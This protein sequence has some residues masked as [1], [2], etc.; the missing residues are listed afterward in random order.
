M[1]AGLSD[2]D[3]QAVAGYLTGAAPGPVVQA[4]PAAPAGGAN[5]RQAALANAPK[6]V[7]KMC[8]THPPIAATGRDWTSV[9]M[10]DR[11]LRY[12]ANPG[13]T[14]ADVPRLKVKWAY[15]MAG[16]GMPTVVGDWLFISNR[17][18]KTYAL[19][20]K[21]GC[22]HWALD[23]AART[24]P[25]VIKSPIS[26]SGWVTFVGERS[27]VVHALD[28]Q[29]GKRSG[30]PSRWRRT[31]SAGITGT[32]IIYG[33]RCSC[34]SPPARKARRAR[35]PTPAAASAARLSPWT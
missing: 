7:D 4:P 33:D 12:Q 11:S 32:P 14:A 15:S 8:E 17:S 25:M 21:T 28:A 18:G 30:R 2:A 29:T 19:D 6:G 31:R 20:A 23:L 10:G 13:L 16:G 34:R 1:A 26:P 27:R 35:P 24:T 22:V 5:A 3:K 9:G